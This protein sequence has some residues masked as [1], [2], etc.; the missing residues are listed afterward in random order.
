MNKYL[1]RL[2]VMK[3]EK[4]LS[5]VPSKPSKPTFEGFE[6]KCGGR[7][8]EKEPMPIFEKGVPPVP[9]K[10]SKGSPP[11]RGETSLKA[12]MLPEVVSVSPMREALAT[13][14]QRCPEYVEAV[15]WQQ[16]VE[17]GRKFLSQW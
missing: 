8:S 12:V 1:D 5:E 16:C 4:G 13:L 3:M 14:E 17:D 10:P 9:S 11:H 2:R 15:R 6:G 7:F